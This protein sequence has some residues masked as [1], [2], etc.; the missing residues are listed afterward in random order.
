MTDQ[1]VV[2]YASRTDVGMRRAVNQDSVAVRL[3]SDLKEWAAQGHLFVVADG[4]GGHSVGDL[5]SRITTD[6]L[7]EAYSGL[8]TVDLMERMRSA[9][10]AANQAVHDR[11]QQNP[12]YSDMGTTCSALS[13][14]PRG[15]IIGHIGDSRIYR[16]RHGLIEQLTFDHS[17]QW[18]MIKIGRATSATVDL[19]HPRNVIT[20]CV[21][22]DP[23]VQVDLEGPFSVQ[24]GDRY[25][26][27]SDGLSNHVSDQE[28]GQIVSS[29]D[30]ND[31]S[32]LLVNLANC[33]GGSDNSTVIVISVENYPAISGPTVDR[34]IGFQDSDT[35]VPMS[36]RQT[37]SWKTPVFFVLELFCLI[38]AVVVY[39]A[40]RSFLV[41]GL[42]IAAMSVLEVLR[43]IQSRSGL[44]PSS[45]ESDS[46]EGFTL[47]AGLERREGGPVEIANASPYR[48]TTAV[49]NDVLLDQLSEIQGE[50]VQAARDSGWSVD[51]DELTQLSRSSVAS[52]QAGKLDKALESR[53]RSIDLLMN[54]LYA[55]AR[56]S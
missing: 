32:R 44:P 21:G 56:A 13:L 37:R 2:K 12:E 42:L 33:R 27:C 47:E 7:P 6:T 46:E 50:L 1:P 14:S 29:L 9:V 11:G 30:T 23:N 19:F 26:L 5:A 4:M 3:C 36:V 17:L 28:I 38:A 20:R 8:K 22:P 51:F 15:L 49:I 40:Q 35:L 18:E 24:Q 53:A 43:R 54:E 52:Q 16:V 45:H 48:F 31:A 34:T 39:V 25:V 41:S 55:R 10:L